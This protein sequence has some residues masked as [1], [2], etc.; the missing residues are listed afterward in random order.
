MVKKILDIGGGPDIYPLAIEQERTKYV[1]AILGLRAVR[2]AVLMPNTDWTVLDPT[3]QR[4]GLEPVQSKIPQ[5]AHLM[6]GKIT[7]DEPAPFED[8]SFDRVEMNFLFSPLLAD[9]YV[10]RMKDPRKALDMVVSLTPKEL[11]ELGD[12]G[13]CIREAARLLK[14]GGRLQIA[15]KANRMDRILPVLY[16]REVQ[17]IGLAFR[18]SGSMPLPSLYSAY[19]SRDPSIY[20]QA[21]GATAT[22]E[23]IAANTPH[24]AIL[25][26]LHR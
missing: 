22:H 14:P 25:D 23:E 24:L 18:T 2:W 16:G 11:H 19:A 10:R 20:T 17:D 5:N 1:E 12:Y 8:E 15:E 26:K 7:E 9:S 13:A 3:L 21:P 6:E 4:R